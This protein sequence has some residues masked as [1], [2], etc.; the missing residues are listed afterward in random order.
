MPDLNSGAFSPTDRVNHATAIAGA[1]RSMGHASGISTG[2]HGGPLFGLGEATEQIIRS[3]GLGRRTP[4]KRT[5]GE[6]MSDADGAKQDVKVEDGQ[7]VHRKVVNG[8][9]REMPIGTQYTQ[10]DRAILDNYPN[11]NHEPMPTTLADLQS[12]LGY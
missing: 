5:H 11:L 10:A 9:V 1:R 12:R 4:D 6:K 2:G 3:S 8:G 7:A